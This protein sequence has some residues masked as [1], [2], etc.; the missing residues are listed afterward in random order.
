MYSGKDD[1]SL[2]EQAERRGSI[3][4]LTRNGASSYF[5]GPDGDTG[6]EYDLAA[7]YADYLGLE[8]EVNVADAFSDL[9]SLLQKQQGEFIAANLTRT[10]ER[11]RLFNFGP[12]Y[13][14]AKT[15]VVYKRG[16]FRPRELSDLIGLNVWVIA[17][18][19]YEGVLIEAQ[20]PLGPNPREIHRNRMGT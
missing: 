11:E 13:A 2:W 19:A 10:P 6:P 1:V 9:G 14:N 17:G 15:L 8:L 12:D 4:V 18:S 20:S 5:I 3:T 16:Q 7:A